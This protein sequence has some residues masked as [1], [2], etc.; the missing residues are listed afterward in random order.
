MF[1][2]QPEYFIALVDRLLSIVSTR[3][4]KFKETGNVN[5]IYKNELDKTYLADDSV[6]ANSKDLAKRTVS[7]KVVKDIGCTKS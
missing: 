4:Q 6:Y 1:L 2:R 3:I 7:E 5:Y